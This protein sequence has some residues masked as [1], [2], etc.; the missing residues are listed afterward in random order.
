MWR[1]TVTFV[2]LNV[3]IEPE[4]CIFSRQETNK[5]VI[6]YYYFIFTCSGANIIFLKKEK[7]LF[8]QNSIFPLLRTAIY[9][10][11]SSDPNL[12]LSFFVHQPPLP[13][14]LLLPST[15]LQYLVSISITSRFKSFKPALFASH[16]WLLRY[17]FP[18]QFF[19]LPDAI[20]IQIDQV[21]VLGFRSHLCLVQ[22]NSLS[23][24]FTWL[25]YNY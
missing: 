3:Y 10:P 23:T 11:R 1:C 20:S 6:C 15:I 9:R 14:K 13:G 7:H 21:L 22:L 16:I 24:T 8:H 17:S 18:L 5:Y 25:S 19:P 12:Q 2:S 4:K